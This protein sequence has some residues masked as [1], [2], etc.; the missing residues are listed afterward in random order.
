MLPLL[1]QLPANGSQLKGGYLTEGKVT[2]INSPTIPKSRDKA[3]RGRKKSSFG[4]HRKHKSSVES[5][6]RK[7]KPKQASG[8]KKDKLTVKR[9]HLL[10]KALQERSA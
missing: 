7:D 8:P 6:N 9:N 5:H 3:N 4:Q 1:N 10:R 2:Q